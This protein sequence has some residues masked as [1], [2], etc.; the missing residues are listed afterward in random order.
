MISIKNKYDC[1]GCGSC[2]QR[3]PQKCIS[4][5]EDN[6]GFLY[7]RIIDSKCI[8][9]G[10][11]ERVCP[12]LNQNNSMLPI[13][14]YAAI[15]P[16]ENIRKQSPSG[17]V[18]SL[19]AEK[20]INE[21]GVVFGAKWNKSWEVVHSYTESII[22]LSDFRGSKYVQSIVGEA[23]IDA[24]RFLKNGRKVLFTGTPCQ[25]AALKLFLRQEYKN[26]ITMDFVCHGIPSP[27]VFRWY[28]QEELNKYVG[29]KNKNIGYLH[30]KLQIPKGI[31]INDIRFRDKSTGW[32]NFSITIELIDMRL[33]NKKL[34]SI[35]KIVCLHPYGQ[36]FLNNYYLR[37][38]CHKCVCK[39]LKSGA[40]ITVADYWG[41]NTLGDLIDDDKGIS[42]VIISTVNGKNLFES[43][44]SYSHI[45]EYRDILSANSA[46]EYSVK[47]PYR[48]YFYSIRRKPFE[49]VVNK[50]TSSSLFCKIAKKVYLLTH[51]HDY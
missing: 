12:M 30:N 13:V 2:V 50:L 21:G 25:I 15:N 36:G 28:L 32:K 46:I 16:N 6:E 40:D 27:G 34:A 8:D 39:K 43:I 17:G 22:G 45:T 4:F 5:Y 10:L 20:V 26:L 14:C 49:E 24:E 33:G 51:G 9:C 44:N 3:C 47:G 41:Y 23:F 48:E 18:F 38:S 37:A 29:E 1:C 11:C 42:A 7:P 35:S 31:Y 19:L